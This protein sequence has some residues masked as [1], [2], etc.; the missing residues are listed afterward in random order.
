VEWAQNCRLRDKVDRSAQP[1]WRGDDDIPGAQ[2]T[3][4][5]LAALLLINLLSPGYAMIFFNWPLVIDLRVGAFRGG[6]GEI[7]LMNA[8][9]AQ[10]SNWLDLPTGI[11]S[12]MTGA[13][14][15]DAQ[16]GSEKAVSALAAG[17]AGGNMI[18]ESSGMMGSLLGASFDAF[19]ADNEMPS[20]IHR[21]I[22]GVEGAEITVQLGGRFRR[23][24]D[25]LAVAVTVEALSDGRFQF[26]GLMYFMVDH[27]QIA[28]EIVC[29]DI[30]GANPC[31]LETIPCTRLKIPLRLGL[32]GLLRSA[33]T[34]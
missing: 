5:T 21:A 22:R 26:T 17:L 30:S 32:G 16:M 8:A 19:V 28:A 34:G 25:P 14:G 3:A 12:S 24:S 31:H 20:H 7:S 4:E 2:T 1:W 29:A 23:Y 15:V 18:Y 6:G 33:P 27:R 10:I 13:K 11:A 9:V